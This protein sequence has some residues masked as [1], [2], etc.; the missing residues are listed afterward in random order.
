MNL[1]LLGINHRTAPV[2][3][4][5]KMNIPEARLDQ[6]GR[7]SWCI[8]TGIREGL[9]LSTC[10]RVEVT[11]SAEDEVDAE[12][13]IRNFPGRPPPLRPRRSSPISS[14]ASG[15]RRW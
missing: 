7:R 11:T 3:V 15:S 5:E 14:I 12:S 8:A 1:T 2:E 13:I 10:N 4:R 6:S 9:I